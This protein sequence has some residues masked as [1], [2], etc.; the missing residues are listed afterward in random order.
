MIHHLCFESTTLTDKRR[1]VERFF[2]SHAGD[3]SK[4]QSHASGSDLQALIDGLSPVGTETALDVGTGTGFTAIYLAGRVKQV[5]GI[6][7]TS[8]MLDQ[9]RALVRRSGVANA[10]FK[11]GDATTIDFPDSSFDLLTTRRATHHFS[12][13]SKFLSEARRVLEPNGRLGIVDMSPPR[14]AEAF[15]NRIEKLRDGSHVKAFT[16]EAWESMVAAAGFQ[17]ISSQVLTERVSFERWLYPV[18]GGGN[19]EEAI[20]SAWESAPDDVKGLLKAEFDGG[21]IIAWSKSR[22]VLIASKTP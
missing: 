5:I 4:S 12:D 2:S 16:P 10:E 6:D 22:V 21:E 13:V 15:T 19:E 1:P 14:G 8:E 18:E 17:V 11:L 9:A 20:R 3:Y 7:L